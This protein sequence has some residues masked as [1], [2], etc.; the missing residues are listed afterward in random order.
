MAADCAWPPSRRP[1]RTGRR[2]RTICSGRS[3]SAWSRMR[4]AYSSGRTSRRPASPRS[5]PG[6]PGARPVGCPQCQRRGASASARRTNSLKL[7]RRDD[8]E[9]H[10]VVAGPR[11]RSRP[12]TGRGSLGEALRAEA[13]DRPSRMW[14]PTVAAGCLGRA[15]VH[16]LCLRAPGAGHRPRR[17][18]SLPRATH[19]ARAG[20]PRLFLTWSARWPAPPSPSPR[21]GPWLTRTQRQ[22]RRFRTVTRKLEEA[23]SQGKPSASFQRTAAAGKRTRQFTRP[24]PAS[25]PGQ[26]PF[27]TAD[28]LDRLGSSQLIEIVDIDG[29]LYV[30]TCGARRSGGSRRA[31]SSDHPGRDF[32][33]FALRRLARSRPG[34]DRTAPCP[35]WP[36]RDPELQRLLGPAVRHW[37]TGPCHRPDRD[38]PPRPVGASSAFADRVVMSPRRR[39]LDGRGRCPAPRQRQVTLARGPG[40]ASEGAEMPRIAP[41]YDDVTV[42]Q[43]RGHGRKG[44]VC[45]GWGPGWD[46]LPR[47]GTRGRRSAVLL[48]ADHDGS[49]TSQT[50]SSCT[51]R[52]TGWCCPAVT[53]ACWRRPAQRAARPGQQPAAA[54]NRGDHRRH[55]AR[56]QRSGC[57]SP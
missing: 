57:E 45:A 25:R 9:R 21:C 17:R 38:T 49:L 55:H 53:P 16:P 12:V 44:A 33:R 19:A 23:Q 54:R 35:S 8:A 1:P 31:A 36:Q 37:A 39:R 52:H 56:L 6:G 14:P 40:L 5:P 32:A 15:P 42:L 27:R 18:T 29:G 43:V 46:I 13:E 34:E 48:A 11:A 4:R 10:W 28:L 20:R 50:S 30:L 41:P 2:P 26:A 47:T 7:G 24:M 51:A 22:P 3:R